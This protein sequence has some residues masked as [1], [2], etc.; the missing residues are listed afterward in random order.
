MVQLDQS[1]AKGGVVGVF[2]VWCFGRVMS[3]YGCFEVC[4]CCLGGGFEVWG[5]CL[6]GGFEVWGCCLGGG[7]EV[8]GL[9]LGWWF[10]GVGVVV[11]MVVL[12]CGGVVWV[13][14]WW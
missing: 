10:R 5:C 13:V 11:R 4:G 9:L 8:W 6:G 1:R 14:D 3:L 7:F 2:M 12:R